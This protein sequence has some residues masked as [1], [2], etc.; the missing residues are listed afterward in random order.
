MKLL[1][2]FLA[3]F[4]VFNYF[5][6]CESFVRK[7][8]FVM[9]AEN[10]EIDHIAL[11]GTV[12]NHENE[13]E[14]QI[15]EP[16]E[17]NKEEPTT[18]TVAP[19]TTSSS[20][21]SKPSSSQSSPSSSPSPEQDDQIEPEIDESNDEEDEENEDEQEQEWFWSLEMADPLN[22]FEQNQ[23]SDLA[24]KQLQTKYKT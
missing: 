3:C 20:D 22:L 11:D 24:W 21:S 6:T 10:F 9:Y 5:K 8:N 13:E 2:L 17:E 18:T 16:A 12:I 23:Q 15:A 1:F 7:Y 14:P 19:A 4:L